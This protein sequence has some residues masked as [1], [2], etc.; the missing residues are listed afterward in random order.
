M[1][2]SRRYTGRLGRPFRGG[3]HTGPLTG[4]AMDSGPAAEPRDA[5]VGV[6]LHV[7]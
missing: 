6:A 2:P 5:I 7:R 3:E 1:V 4:T